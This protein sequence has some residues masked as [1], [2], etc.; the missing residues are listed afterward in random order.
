VG[1]KTRTPTQYEKHTTVTVKTPDDNRPIVAE[2]R[3]R[4]RE[5]PTTEISQLSDRHATINR[6]THDAPTAAYTLPAAQKQN[7]NHWVGIGL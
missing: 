3:K 6:P 5:K 7:V 4:M 1:N 2:K